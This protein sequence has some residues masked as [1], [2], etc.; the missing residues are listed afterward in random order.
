MRKIAMIPL[1]LGSTRVKDKSLLLIYG[2]TMADYVIS[3]CVE[4]N[5]FDEIYVNTE[6]D[7]FASL[8][9]KYGVKVYNRNPNRGGTSCHMKNKSSQCDGNRCSVNDHFLYD[10]MSNVPSDYVF[11][12]HDTSPLILPDTIRKFVDKTVNSEYDSM[13]SVVEEYSE[14]FL[15]GKP[16]NFNRAKKTPTQKLNPIQAVT[17]ALSGWKC[18][19][20]LQAYMR[21]AVDENG[22]TFCGNVGLVTMNKIEALDVDTWEDFHL[23]ES[24]LYR[25]HTI[26]NRK[27]YYLNSDEKTDK[28]LERLIKEDGVTNFYNGLANSQ[29]ISL[30]E[31]KKAM[32]EPPWCCIVAYSDT[33]T[34]GFI[35]QNPGGSCRT[36]YHVTKDEWWYVVEGEF[37]WHLDDRVIKAKKG[38]IVFLEQGTKHRIYCVGDKPGIRLAHGSRDMEHIYIV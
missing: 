20:F 16:I 37:E 1:S 13:L 38:D 18:E 19:S 4:A 34:A 9:E 10:F 30:D 31:I 3:A 7:V 32:G 26:L 27:S 5:V 15:N 24:Y 17:W 33:D 28:N 6:H 25:R 11:L 23:V 12:V 35:C 14:S 22:P 36:H 2:Q 29:H 8:A 21:D